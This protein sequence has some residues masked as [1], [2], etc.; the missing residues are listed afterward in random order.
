M[1]NDQKLLRPLW[2][3]IKIAGAGLIVAFLL[4]REPR[5]VFALQRESA[6]VT[7][8]PPFTEITLASG[9][10]K[11]TTMVEI[12]NK[13]MGHQSIRLSILDFGALDESGGVAFAG[14]RGSALQQSYSLASWVSLEKDS[15]EIDPGTTK[16]IIVSITNKGSLSPGGH[17]AAVVASSGEQKTKGQS[18]GLKSAIA[19]LLFVK[20]TG[21]EIYGLSLSGSEVTK[22]RLM[23]PTEVNLRFQNT[24][25]VH[26]VPRGTVTVN[27]PWG[28]EIFKG[29][30]NPQSGII[31]PENF[32]VYPTTLERLSL[33]LW[34]GMYQ[35]II[36]YRYETQ[37]EAVAQTTRFFFPG[38]VGIGLVSL[39]IISLARAG[40]ARLNL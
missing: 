32:R 12:A 22:R 24:G 40:L 7:I 20:K 36:S 2:P 3:F 6:G 10:S 23:L 9:Q 35:L 28:T 39:V 31:L 15:L 4:C 29:I 25:N 38:L 21:G 18:I 37:N 27:G 33:P 11:T 14:S 19:S 1:V 17:Y 8:S 26:V 5:A 16:K 30:I 34:P 13:T